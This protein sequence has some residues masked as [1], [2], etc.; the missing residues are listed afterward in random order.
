MGRRGRARRSGGAGLLPRRR[1]PLALLGAAAC[2]RRDGAEAPRGRRGSGGRVEIV[3]RHQPLGGDPAPFRA[4]LDA[5]RRAHP[6]IDLRTEALPNAAD[7]AHQVFLTALEAGGTDVDVFVVDVVWVAEFARA[8][9]VADLSDA[10]PPADLRR[11]FLPGPLEAV[12][13]GGR[14]FAVPFYVDVGIL[15]YRT[16]LVPAP[17]RTYDELLRLAR[18]ARAPGRFGYLWQGRQY[19]GLT[20]NVYEAIWGHGGE[21][22]RDGRL[23]LDAPPAR[24]ALAHLRGL[25]ESGASPPTV[26]AAAEEDARRLFQAGRAALMRNWPYA[27]TEAQAPGSPVRGRVG[28]APLP[29][30]TG[31]P[32]AGALGGWQL[33]VG[34][35]LTGAR[36]EAA[37]ALVAH[38]TSAQANRILLRHYGRHPPRAAVYDDPDLRRELP[39]LAILAGALRAARPRPVTPY[40]NLIAD[41]LQSEFSAAVTGLRPPGEALARAQRQ[42]DRVMGVTP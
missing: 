17:P 14:T 15:H 28:L 41:V 26:T 11:D 16:D 32:G 22:L 25:V 39:T 23:L 4:W 34:A 7:L 40:Y 10:F 12:L 21:A 19:E 31:A 35:H 1:L 2:L 13:V 9:W 30:A 24:A 36:R 38:L 18:A 33:A 27:W 42:V 37:I 3:F 29:T 6:E 5:F 8:G 20:C